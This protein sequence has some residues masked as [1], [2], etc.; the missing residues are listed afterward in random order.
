MDSFW[1]FGMWLGWICRRLAAVG[2]GRC[3]T[4]LREELEDEFPEVVVRCE[5]R[6]LQRDTE[7]PAKASLFCGLW[8]EADGTSGCSE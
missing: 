7:N 6:A 1:K 4:S 5:M 8:K 2:K 3:V